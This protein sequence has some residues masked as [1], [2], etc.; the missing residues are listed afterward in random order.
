MSKAASASTLKGSAGSKP[1][2]ERVFFSVDVSRLAGV[3]QR[4]LQWWDERKVVSP[5]KEDHRRVYEPQQV[6]EILTVAALRHKGLSLQKVRRV[7]RAMR[8]EMSRRQPLTHSSP[9]QP[10]LYVL[11]DGR[12]IL[13]EERPE[14]ILKCLTEAR[15]GMYLICI[16]EQLA[17]FTSQ[18]TPPAIGRRNWRSFD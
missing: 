4:Q 18:K 5:R 1:I 10:E 6:L 7:L 9:G 17:R 15:N 14:R 3:S 16:S 11:T 2:G 8:R 13:V 12:S